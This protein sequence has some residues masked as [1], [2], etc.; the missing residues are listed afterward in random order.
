MLGSFD[1]PPIV[2]RASP[3]RGALALGASA[4][5]DAGVAAAVVAGARVDATL[6]LYLAFFGLCAVVG[7]WMLMAPARLVIGPEGL[8]ERVL[9]A[10]KLYRWSEVYDFRPAMIGLTSTTVGFSFTAQR[11]GWAPLRRLNQALSGVADSLN[12]GW[13]IEP[14][15]LAQLLNAS[16]ERWLDTAGT[17]RFAAPPIPE[18][19][20][21]A[22]MNRKV[23]AVAWTVLGGAAGALTFVP[24]I[25]DSALILVL[26]FGA[27]LHAARLHDIGVSGWWQLALY[28][29]QGAAAVIALT[30]RAEPEVILGALAVLQLAF[31]AGLSGIPGD[32][33]PNPFG[34]APGQATP[35]VTA[36]AFR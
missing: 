3:A 6:A 29:L 2:V 7:L 35:L 32:P 13:E 25:G 21:G 5:V 9:G 26:I 22:R 19:A 33:A 4:V 30:W 20:A 8:T 23:Y 27:R 15:A 16:R 24:Q 18:G 36:E 14:L 12:A 11:P 31:T 34:P 28:A 1:Q 10:V 17:A